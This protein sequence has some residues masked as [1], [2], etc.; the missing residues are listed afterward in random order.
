MAKIPKKCPVCGAISAKY[1]FR[2]HRWPLKNMVS[3][4]KSNAKQELFLKVLLYPSLKT[5]HFDYVKNHMIVVKYP[6]IE[7][8]LNP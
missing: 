7:I 2:E 1:G 5:P 6:S 3:H 8:K 4:I